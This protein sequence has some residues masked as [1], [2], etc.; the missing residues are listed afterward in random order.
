[1]GWFMK[2]PQSRR[3]LMPS[4]RASVVLIFF[5]RTSTNPDVKSGSHKATRS[6][7]NQTLDHG[8][9]LLV[10]GALFFDASPQSDLFGMN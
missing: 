1:M 2:N 7:A 4:F 10:P 3:H 5:L 8:E 6:S 9:N